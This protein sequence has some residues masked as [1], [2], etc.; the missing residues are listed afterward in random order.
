[1]WNFAGAIHIKLL[2]HVANRLWSDRGAVQSTVGCGS[3]HVANC[4][5]SERGAVQSTVGGGSDHA[6]NRLWSDRGDLPANIAGTRVLSTLPCFG[7][8]EDERRRATP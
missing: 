5:W 4:L 6:A 2:D 1:M 8:D 3:D 7:M